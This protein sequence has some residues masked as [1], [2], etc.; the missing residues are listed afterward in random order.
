MSVL[1]G[2]AAALAQA[3]AASEL[4]IGVVN[5]QRLVTE[6]PQG[7]AASEA[8]RT[9]FMPKQR[10][11]VQLGAQ[12]KAKQ[13]KLEKDVAT[14]SQDQRARAEKELSEGNKD[15]SRKQSD[16][17][18]E[19]NARQ[20]EELSKLEGQMVNETR[21]YAQGQKLDLVLAN[22]AVIYATNVLDITGA[23][24][25]YLQAKAPP[26]TPAAPAAAPAAAPPGK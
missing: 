1:L 22:N 17:Q 7:K 25:G 21:T 12:L 14:M 13:D 8:L 15:F 5:F 18:E 4:K 20:N 9:E 3:Q 11:L 26:A 16:L 19:F 2:G 23:V 24:L 6:S 10:D